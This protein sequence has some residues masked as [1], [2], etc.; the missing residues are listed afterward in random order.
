MIARYGLGGSGNCSK[1]EIIMDKETCRDA[2]TKLN[3]P[4]IE[5]L[6]ESKCYK[7]STGNCLQNDQPTEGASLICRITE[8]DF[9]KYIQKYF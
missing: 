1:G 9:G 6:G 8:I 4:E 3:L 7:D 5:I 2:C